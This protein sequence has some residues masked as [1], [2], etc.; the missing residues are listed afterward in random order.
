MAAQLNPLIIWVDMGCTIYDVYQ[1][2][3][4]PNPFNVGGY[5]LPI[6]F[7]PILPG[8]LVTIVLHLPYF[9]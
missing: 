7:K 8:L 2:F 3:T 4:N 6:E 5:G 1:K 9:K